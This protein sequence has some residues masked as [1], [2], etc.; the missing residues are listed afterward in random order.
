LGLAAAADAQLTVGKLATQDCWAEVYVENLSGVPVWFDDLEIQTGALPVAVVVK[1]THYD[2]WGLELAGIGYNASGNPEHRWKFNGGVERT[3][4]FG[5]H[6]DESG[7][8]MYDMQL[9]R[10]HGVDLL[11]HKREW[12]TTFNFVQ[13][14]PI[15]RVDPDGK[16]D[17]K[18][19]KETGQVTQVGEKN[20]Q[21]DRIL[22]TDKKGNVVNKGNGFLVRKS[23]RGKPKV[24]IDNIER[25]IL[26]DKMNLRENDNVIKVG[27][28]G[29]ATIAGF[30]DFALNISNYLDKEVGGYYLANKAD[31]KISAVYLN[32]YK[33]ND[34]QKAKGGFRLQSIA[35]DLYQSTVP[36]TSFH[37]H[38]TR[39]GDKDRLQESDGDK[40]HKK[41]QSGEPNCI[42][43]FIVITNP[44]T[45]EY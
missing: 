34:A 45:F 33:G 42:L 4:D 27:G 11:A 5:L 1:E 41:G 10:F 23:E 12:L 25:G 39:F 24:E 20:D 30:E 15:L 29:E 13:C 18:F 14:N 38:L 8:R 19:D 32:K 40:E 22:K 16:T 7:A 31:W 37:T 35:P 28:Q 26:R 21:P 9:G 36:H 43:R 2:P 17:F 6:W 44:A 3:S